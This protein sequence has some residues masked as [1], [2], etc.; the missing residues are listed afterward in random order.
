MKENKPATIKDVALLAG[1]A[2]STVSLVL[3]SSDKVRKETR[4]KVLDAVKK[5]NYV[6]NNFAVSLRQSHYICLGVLVPDLYNSFYLEIVKGLR[7]RCNE[8]G[9]PIYVSETKNSL[10]EEERQISYL[11]SIKVNCFVFIGTGD[12]DTQLVQNLLMNPNNHVAYADKYD[13]TGTIPHVVIDNYRSAYDA[14]TCL[15]QNG[16]ENVYYVTQKVM[17]APVQKRMDGVIDAMK[18]HGIYSENKIVVANDVLLGKLEAGYYAMTSILSKEVPDGVM[19]SSDYL[20]IG[21]KRVLSER[22][23]R[24]PQDVSMIGFDNI[25]ISRYTVPSLSTVNQ[26]REQMGRLTFSLVTDRDATYT[27]AN[28]RFVLQHDFIIR[29]SIRSQKG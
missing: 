20:A 2:P 26:P 22:G 8:T 18:Q 12:D 5:L 28:N 24:I 1:V 7:D 13:E 6:P 10:A 9:Y 17:S 19:A 16:C 4:D 21:M 14:M 15:I 27:A 11:R 3:N 23:L 25:D 29:E